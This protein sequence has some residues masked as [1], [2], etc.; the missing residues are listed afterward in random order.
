MKI[1]ILMILL[2]SLTL[3]N[4]AAPEYRVTDLG[5]LPGDDESFAQAINSK[6]QVVGW[7]DKKKDH[8]SGHAFLWQHGRMQPL[9]ISGSINANAYSINDFGQIVGAFVPQGLRHNE[10]EHLFLWSGGHTADLGSLGNSPAGIS[11]NNRGQIAGLSASDLR[12]GTHALLYNHGKRI[13]LGALPGS[14]YSSAYAINNKGQVVGFSI[15]S[16][17][18]HGFLW[19]KG[20]MRDLGVLPGYSSSMA[21]CLNDKGQVAG[22]SL[23]VR[24][25]G[26]VGGAFLWQNGKMLNLGALPGGGYSQAHGINNKGQVVGDA[27]HKTDYHA[28]LWQ[29]GALH[30]LN[31]FIPARSGWFLESATGINNYGQI[32]GNG[33]IKGR[34]HAFLLTPIHAR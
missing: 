10:Y 17:P 3:P 28:F 31:N 14:R 1:L 11:I 7:C 21:T 8:H 5:T 26:S 34:Y 4:F 13:N 33:S 32:V 29:R 16:R 27:Y 24:K 2:F 12:Q 20:Q 30:D 19:Q 18:W 23:P 22:Q 25:S 6:G 15:M 9:N